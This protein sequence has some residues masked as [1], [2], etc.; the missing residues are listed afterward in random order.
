M[1]DRLKILL[2]AATLLGVPL[3]EEDAEAHAS[4]ATGEN[5]L[6]SLQVCS[7]LRLVACGERWYTTLRVHLPMRFP[8]SSNK[9]IAQ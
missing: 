1:T 6:K 8:G 9:S 5:L 3:D 2:Q 4:W 7:L